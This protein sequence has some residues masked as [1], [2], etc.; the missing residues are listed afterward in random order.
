MHAAI[1]LGAVIV[2]GLIVADWAAFNLRTAKAVGYGVSVG[3][4]RE[5]LRVR[6]EQFNADGILTLPRGVARL[7]Q[8]RQAVLLQPDKRLLGLSFRTAWPLNGT[9]HYAALGERA[10]ATLVKRM[11]WSSVL[12]T[13]LW[14]L[15]VAVG[16]LVYLVSY[17]L[18]GGFSSVGGAFLALALGGLAL[19]VLLFGTLVVVAAYRLE[20]K[21]LMAVYEEFKAAV[22]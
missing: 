10:P 19:L 1:F 22:A 3:R 20:D 7:C 6:R 2:V 9:V 15:T 5:T 17:A 12:L 4:H 14:F 21:R 16:L 8:E 11:P 13:A 18:A